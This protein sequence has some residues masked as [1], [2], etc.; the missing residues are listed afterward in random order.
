MS[1][2]TT[3]AIGVAI[4]AL[5]TYGPIVNGGNVYASEIR[6]LSALRTLTRTFHHADDLSEVVCTVPDCT[7][8]DTYQGAFR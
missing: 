7:G 8:C 3:T 4:E 6:I 1:S 2:E 5:K